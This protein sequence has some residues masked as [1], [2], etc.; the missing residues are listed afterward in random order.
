MNYSM[1]SGNGMWSWHRFM[2]KEELGKLTFWVSPLEY[3]KVKK[4][5]WIGCIF[6]AWHPDTMSN[7]ANFNAFYFLFCTILS[8]FSMIIVS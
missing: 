6:L 3:G 2:M 8:L 5:R 7:T 4:K 1:E